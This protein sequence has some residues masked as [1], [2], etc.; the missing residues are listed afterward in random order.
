MK[1]QLLLV[2][3][4]IG[5]GKSTKVK[6]LAQ[7]GWIVISRDALRYMIGGSKYRFDFALEEYIRKSSLAVLEVFLKSKK[8]IVIDDVNISRRW[9][10]IYV[11][12]AKKYNYEL[13]AHVLPRLTKKESVDRRL[14]NNHGDYTRFMWNVVWERF[15]L[16]YQMPTLKEG[17]DSITIEEKV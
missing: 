10:A 13:R 2:V 11:K 9:R 6:H 7:Q 16:V 14:S 15:N 3:G 8:N 1:P 5:S 12:L 17:F 4:N